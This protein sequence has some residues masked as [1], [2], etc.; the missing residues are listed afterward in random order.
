MIVVAVEHLDVDACF[1]HPSSELAQ[2]T[3]NGL[4]ESL[5]HHIAL[6]DHPNTCVLERRARGVAVGKEE[7]RDP[8]PVDDP[9]PSA[10]DTHAST[11][12]RLAHLTKRARPIVEFY[13]KIPDG[14]LRSPGR[15]LL[16]ARALRAI[17][18]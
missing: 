7:V 13:R 4:F 6:G 16:T 10:F 9:S 5:D 17:A 3:W 15:S 8:A 11:T 18:K 12:Q 1:S 14:R 2:L